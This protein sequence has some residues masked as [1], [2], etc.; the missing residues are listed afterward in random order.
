MFEATNKLT[1]K[2]VF[3]AAG[4]EGKLALEQNSAPRPSLTA[5][6]FWILEIEVSAP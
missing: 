3:F 5:N 4:D 2:D 6:R 1:K